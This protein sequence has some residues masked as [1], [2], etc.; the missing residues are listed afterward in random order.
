MKNQLWQG[1]FRERSEE[2]QDLIKINIRKTSIFAGVLEHLQGYGGMDTYIIKEISRLIA[3][4]DSI[5]LAAQ[6]KSSHFFYKGFLI[7]N[8][9]S[10]SFMF[11]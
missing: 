9:L 2:L 1:M 11:N 10:T 6:N 4:S 7:Q 8:Q 5:R 3:V